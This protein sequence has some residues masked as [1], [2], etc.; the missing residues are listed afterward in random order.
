MPP[1]PRRQSVLALSEVLVEKRPDA[2][3]GVDLLR[4]IFLEQG[5]VVIFAGRGNYLD[6]DQYWDICENCY[7]IY[8]DE[9]ILY[10]QD[11]DYF[12]FETLPSYTLEYVFYEGVGIGQTR[13]DFCFNFGGIEVI[14][15]SFD[16]YVG[17]RPTLM[18]I[19]SPRN[20]CSWCGS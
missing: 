19:S 12:Y 1:P 18:A 2:V 7:D 16:V 5:D 9:D 3:P 15:A 10:F 4:R 20:S 6:A 13:I 14:Q 8:P 11:Y 17:V